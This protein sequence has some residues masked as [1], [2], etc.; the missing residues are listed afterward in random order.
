MVLWFRNNTICSIIRYVL[1]NISLSNYINSGS[2]IHTLTELY[3]IFMMFISTLSWN[4]I[5]DLLY[6]LMRIDIVH[7]LFVQW[8]VINISIIHHNYMLLLYLCLEWSYNNINIFCVIRWI[9][10]YN[11]YCLLLFSLIY[12]LLRAS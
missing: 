2:S 8:S 11:I 7:F 12:F 3:I 4:I 9:Y 10:L 5:K 1:H 6:I